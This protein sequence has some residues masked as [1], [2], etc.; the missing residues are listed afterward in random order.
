MSNDQVIEPGLWLVA[1]PIGNLAD[2]SDRAIQVLRA[3]H[4]VCCE[5]TRHSGRLLQ[6]IGAAPARLIVANDHT[7]H[8]AIND[9]MSA[10]ASGRV[11]SVIT[12]AGTPGISDPGFRLTRAAIDA[13]H[14]VHAVPGPSAFVMAAVLSGFATDRIAFDGFLPR[15]GAERRERLAEAARERRT[16]VLY[17][18]P[19]RMEET[20]TDLLAACG[21]ARHIMIARELTKLHETLWRGTLGDAIECDEVK[22]PRGEYV[23]VIEGAQSAI[24]DV[25]DDDIVRRL[26]TLRESGVSTRDAVDEVS[27]V[28]QVARKRVYD[29]AVRQ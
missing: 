8:G 21:D 3:S 5:D 16:V 23:L 7:E 11:V 19:H 22:S 12:D 25:T 18:A 2:L 13:G 14:T 20:I 15:R 4:V 1:T 29:I 24:T 28:L 17:E 9:V 26:N 6:H 10:L 27:T